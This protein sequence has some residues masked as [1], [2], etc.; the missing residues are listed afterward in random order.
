MANTGY[1]AMYVLYLLTWEEFFCFVLNV[2][3]VGRFVG[4]YEILY[5]TGIAG[6]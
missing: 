2:S 6:L 4:R 1:H 5:C 3:V